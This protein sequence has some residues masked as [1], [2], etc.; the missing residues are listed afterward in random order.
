MNYKQ[1][2]MPSEVGPLYL[3][4]CEKGLS[5]VF[6]KKQKDTPM[7]DGK[8]E[9]LEVFQKTIQ[10]LT[11]YF[12]GT[13]QEFDLVLAPMGT[14]FQKKVWNELLKIPYGKTCSYKDI[15]TRLKDPNACRA[16]GAANGKNPI[17]IIVPCHRVV[18][19]NGALTG[20][21]GSVPVK[22]MLL[23]LEQRPH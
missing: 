9:H 13:R 2:I 17:S 23:D 10:Q 3:V 20:Y 14:D 5:G 15:A 21:A 18:G 8:S 7:T 11:E 12:A 22:K 16:V 6:W 4:A 19:A 1:M